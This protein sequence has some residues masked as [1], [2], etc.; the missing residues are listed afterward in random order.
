MNMNWTLHLCQVKKKGNKEVE[1]RISCFR[2]TQKRATAVPVS[3]LLHSPRRWA[4]QVAQLVSLNTTWTW[5]GH[6]WCH[7]AWIEHELNMSWTWIVNWTWI[8]HELNTN[9]TLIGRSRW[10]FIWWLRSRTRHS[11]SLQKNW[12]WPRKQEKSP[13][14]QGGRNKSMEGSVTLTST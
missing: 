8:E 3:W 13:K 11:T 12:A 7:W 4:L 10:E 1:N 6:Y 5:T 9:W 2:W 14:P